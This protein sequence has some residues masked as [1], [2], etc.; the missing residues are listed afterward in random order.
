MVLCHALPAEKKTSPVCHCDVSGGEKGCRVHF[1]TINK[2]MT[3]AAPRQKITPATRQRILLSGRCG[4]RGIIFVLY[5]SWE[6]WYAKKVAAPRIIKAIQAK[7]VNDTPL[8]RAMEEM[9]QRMALTP[10]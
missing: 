3:T 7:A 2:E 4:V 9:M 8:G 1:T 5:L 6:N 10:K